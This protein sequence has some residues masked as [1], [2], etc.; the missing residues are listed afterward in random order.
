M[1]RDIDPL[2]GPY[3]RG[4]REFWFLLVTL[5]TANLL[6]W[7][8]IYCGLVWLVTPKPYTQAELDAIYRSIGGDPVACPVRYPQRP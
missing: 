5:Q 3:D 7:F 8:G 4:N 2:L 1:S 6:F